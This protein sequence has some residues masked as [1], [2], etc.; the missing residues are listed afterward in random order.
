MIL[1]S[2]SSKIKFKN[3]RKIEVTATINRIHKYW[4]YFEL[5]TKLIRN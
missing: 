4:M 2:L 5:Q 1:H 3:R